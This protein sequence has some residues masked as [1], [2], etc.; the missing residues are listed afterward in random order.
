[1]NIKFIK[2]LSFNLNEPLVII[3]QLHFG[4]CQMVSSV[5]GKDLI[6]NQFDFSTKRQLRC[7]VTCC[8]G[9]KVGDKDLELFY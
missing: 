6:Q 3:A 1:M 5:C 9:P 4:V 8:T 2:K 7:I